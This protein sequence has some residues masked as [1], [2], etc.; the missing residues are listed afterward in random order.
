MAI[1]EDEQAEII[2]KTFSLLFRVFWNLGKSEQDRFLQPCGKVLFGIARSKLCSKCLV[3][4]N[5]IQADSFIH[6]LVYSLKK[7][8]LLMRTERFVWKKRVLRREY[9]TPSYQFPP[10][11]SIEKN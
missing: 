9:G 7:E 1:T 2:A 8:A 11:A 5:G 6:L 4:Q 3:G 10:L